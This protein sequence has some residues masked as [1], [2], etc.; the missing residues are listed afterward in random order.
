[1][2]KVT[3]EEIFIYCAGGQGRHIAFLIQ[4]IGGY[5]IRGFI[6]ENPKLLGQKIKGFDVFSSIESAFSGNEDVNVAI[7]NGSPR[8]VYKIVRK[9]RNYA[10][11][12]ECQIKFPNLIHPSVLYDTEGVEFGVGNIVNVG[13]NFTT[14]IV[15]GDFNYFNRYC[16][17][18]HDLV[19]GSYCNFNAGVIVGGN[20]NIGDF[21]YLGMG[22]RIIQEKTIG[23][24]VLLGAGCVIQ[25]DVVDNAV[26]VMPMARHFR[27]NRVIEK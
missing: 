15:V 7:A 6:D 16:V 3:K 26:M 14:D 9:L 24:N 21:S 2:E 27:T 23:E 11:K 19:V 5:K 1:M 8:T 17:L 22:S 13:T 18:G 25:K 10:R 12:N 4:Q 20:V